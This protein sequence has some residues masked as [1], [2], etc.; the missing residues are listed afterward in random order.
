MSTNTGA[1]NTNTAGAAVPRQDG[2]SKTSAANGR[3]SRGPTSPEGKATVSKN[4]I[5]HGLTTKHPVLASEDHRPYDRIVEEYFALY[6]PTNIQERDIVQNIADASW[7]LARLKRIE[8][9]AINTEMAR[10]RP[11]LD[12]EFQRYSCGTLEAEAFAKLSRDKTLD[13]FDRHER[14]LERTL[15]RSFEAL[16]K[17]RAV[18]GPE[19]PPTPPPAPADVQNKPIFPEPP[20]ATPAPDQPAGTKAQPIRMNTIQ[21]LDRP[22]PGLRGSPTTPRCLVCCG[23]SSG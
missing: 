23:G 4:A 19:A 17:L 10:T 7:R 3:K 11:D 5:R 13:S 2:R 1:N 22:G 16:A 8:K 6:S 15:L 18:T 12:G 21:S 14:R 9:E 20:P